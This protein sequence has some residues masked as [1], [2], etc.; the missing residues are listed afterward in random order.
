MLDELTARQDELNALAQSFQRVRSFAAEL[1]RTTKGK[2]FTIRSALA[3]EALLSL[4]RAV[5]I[6]LAAWVDNLQAPEGGNWLRRHI[7][8]PHL[9]S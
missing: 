8:G 4:H 7:Q 6:D 1:R 9:A 5:V 2:R 3:W